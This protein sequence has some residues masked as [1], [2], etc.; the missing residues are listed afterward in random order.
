MAS[1][2]EADKV[3]PDF[4]TLL[5]PIVGNNI[6]STNKSNFCQFLLKSAGNHILHVKPILT[7][8]SEIL[9]PDAGLSLG[10]NGVGSGHK[11]LCYDCIYRN[12]SGQRYGQKNCDD[13]FFYQ[14]LHRVSCGSG[15]CM[16]SYKKCTTILRK[17]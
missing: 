4:V 11:D 8:I 9:S 13:H 7:E 3:L 12:I 17:I 10:V 5:T 14:D 2:R 6:C 16:V 1:T 15:Y